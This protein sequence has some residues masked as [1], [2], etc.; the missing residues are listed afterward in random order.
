M[1]RETV[2]KPSGG[3]KNQFCQSDPKGDGTPFMASRKSVRCGYS[4]RFNF[5]FPQCVPCGQI[6][7]VDR[8]QRGDARQECEIVCVPRRPKMRL[9]PTSFFLASW[10]MT[11]PIHSAS[12]IGFTEWPHESQA[13]TKFRE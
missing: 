4:S 7:A 1:P 6:V 13:L 8:L 10:K 5:R 11:R 12:R 9:A 3:Y 2:Y